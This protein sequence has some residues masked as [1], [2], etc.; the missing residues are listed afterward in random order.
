MYSL[1][2]RRERYAIIYV[3]KI[4]EGLVPNFDGLLKVHSTLHVRRGRLCIIPP[5]SRQRSTRMQTLRESSF[6]VIGP[7]LFNC[8]PCELRSY[9]GNPDG[10]KNK[11]DNFL[12]AVPDKP[13]LPHYYQAPRGNSIL[14]QV[15]WGR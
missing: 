7:R 11:L 15:G 13:H 10:F 5:L 1:E 6:A 4:L 2:R 12:S 9:E 8:L 14:D 3:W